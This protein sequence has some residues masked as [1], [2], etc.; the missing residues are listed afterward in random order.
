MLKIFIFYKKMVIPNKITRRTSLIFPSLRYEV[1]ARTVKKPICITSASQHHIS[2]ENIL[3]FKLFQPN[4]TQIMTR[5]ICF[6]CFNKNNLEELLIWQCVRL[7]I[8]CQNLNLCLRFQGNCEFL[9]GI[10]LANY[11]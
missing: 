8:L 4:S 10:A 3:P 2:Y 7:S 6:C 11:L 9:K 5:I 1:I